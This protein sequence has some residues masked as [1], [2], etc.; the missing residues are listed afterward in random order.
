VDL[1]PCAIGAEPVP[2]PHRPLR[3]GRPGRSRHAIPMRN[4]Y[5]IPSTTCRV[6]AEWPCPHVVRGRHQRI[7]PL[8]PSV[9]QHSLARNV[10][11]RSAPTRTRKT[12]PGGCPSRRPLTRS[13]RVKRLEG[14]SGPPGGCW[15]PIPFA[16]GPGPS[17]RTGA[18]S[19]DPAQ[20]E[21]GPPRS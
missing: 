21:I 6:I 13:F 2:L 20:F 11:S 16:R 1:V 18:D 8:S 14:Q 15:R 12:R 17:S 7:D 4:R 19:P 5:I 10:R 3:A 9:S